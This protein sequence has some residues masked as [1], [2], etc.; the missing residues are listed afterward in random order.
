MPEKG[1]ERAE[2][3]RVSP[4]FLKFPNP[5]QS[6]ALSLS[7]LFSSY[8]FLLPIHPIL[9][10]RSSSIHHHLHSES[11]F[12]FI[13]TTLASPEGVSISSSQASSSA[14]Y[15]H[16]SL[17]FHSSSHPNTHTMEYEDVLTNQPVVIDNVSQ[18]CVFF[19]KQ[20]H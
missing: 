14:K 19:H 8:L 4:P 5:S 18:P 13:V 7:A 16:P 20:V 17:Y 2:W 6:L 11:I 3:Q 10:F 12:L 1:F 15:P 9:F